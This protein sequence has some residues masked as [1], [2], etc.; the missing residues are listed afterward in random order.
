V[1][2]C[3][4]SLSYASKEIN[5]KKS[6]HDGQLFLIR[7]LIILREQI[8][9]FKIGFIVV[10][11]HLDFSIMKDAFSSFFKGNFSRSLLGSSP[12]VIENQVDSKKV[13]NSGISAFPFSTRVTHRSLFC[14]GFRKRT[15]GQY[16]RLFF[17][18]FSHF[19]R[20]SG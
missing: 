7:H 14:A 18:F 8:T 20:S 6:W 4:S 5:K 1:S 16:H 11:K 19:A 15:C 9:P 3:C 2:E 12:R 17:S 10:E 13:N